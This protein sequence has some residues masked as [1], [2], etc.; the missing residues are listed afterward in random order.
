MTEDDPRVER[1]VAAEE[2][3]RT[4]LQLFTATD[5]QRWEDVKAV[6][7]PSV[8]FDMTSLA[9]GSPARLTPD[10]IAGAWEAGLRPIE[11]VH[12]QVGNLVADLDGDAATASCYGI[13][14]HHRNTRSGRNTRVFVGSYDFHLVRRGARWVIDLFRFNLKFVDGNRELEA[15]EPAP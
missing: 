4:I 15:E 1:L 14:Y 13:A 6:L 9:G 11:A 10:E 5:A 8:T 3:R 2:V 12:H 7:A